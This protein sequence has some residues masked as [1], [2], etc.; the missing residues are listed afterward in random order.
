MGQI[1]FTD[2]FTS[3]SD[4]EVKFQFIF[5]K[6]GGSMAATRLIALHKNKGK[7]VAACLK[8]RMKNLSGCFCTDP[9]LLFLQQESY[10][11]LRMQ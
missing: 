1:P 5:K 4:F 7:S 2:I 8:S 10:F 6:G 9:Y 11:I 3:V